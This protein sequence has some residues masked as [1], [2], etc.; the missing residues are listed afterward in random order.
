M[1]TSSLNAP[2]DIIELR[3]IASDV[4]S[5]A[6]KYVLEE[7][8]NPILHESKSSASDLVTDIDKRTEALIVD[9]IKNQRPDDSFLGEEGTSQKGSSN[10]LWIIDPIDGT[11]NFVH[12]H[13]GFGVS[14]AAK[15]DDVI[16]AG[17]VADPKHKELFDAAIGSGARC[18]GEHITIRRSPELKTALVA[19][20]FSYQELDRKVQAEVLAHVLPAI[21]DIRRM[22][23]AAIDLCSVA[24]GRVDAFYETGL[25][26]WD[27]AA[28]SLI[29]SEAGAEVITMKSFAGEALHVA[30]NT[31]IKSEFLALLN[32][33]MEKVTKDI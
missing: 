29:A 12:E 26:E 9:L 2:L 6:G 21:A 27:I 22:G 15:F 31:C 8:K 1:M 16:V 7:S 10:V 25:N 23:S 20:G 19:T 32:S 28:G 4:A 30:V 18:N 14:I 13:P 5:Q 24:M 3:N 17:A 11:T 33:A